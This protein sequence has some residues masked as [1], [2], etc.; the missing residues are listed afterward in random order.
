MMRKLTE[1]L[2]Q[3]VSDSILLLK[4]STSIIPANAINILKNRYC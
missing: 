4:I 2:L 3:A 1:F